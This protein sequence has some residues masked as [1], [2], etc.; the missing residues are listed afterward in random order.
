MGRQEGLSLNFSRLM[1]LI[2]NKKTYDDLLIEK[3]TMD[4][5]DVIWELQHV[6]RVNPAALA[7]E[8]ER[9]KDARDDLITIVAKI[10]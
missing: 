8:K 9:L 2:M 3:M 7:K 6:A 10:A 5:V 1:G 4:A